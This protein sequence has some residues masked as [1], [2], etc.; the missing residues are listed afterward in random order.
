VYG[1]DKIRTLATFLAAFMPADEEYL[2]VR[3]ETWLVSKL[4]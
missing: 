2:Y 1:S 4:D 3:M